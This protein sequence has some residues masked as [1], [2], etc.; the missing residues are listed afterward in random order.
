MRA[1]DIALI[2]FRL[3]A[4]WFAVSAIQALVELL[5][6]WKSFYAQISSSMVGV[7]NPLT[8]RQ[9]FL[10]TTSAMVGRTMVGIGLW[11]LAPHLARVS[12]PDLSAP[13]VLQPSRA[14]LFHAASFLAGVWLLGAAVPG[15]VF[16]GI[17]VFR[18]GLTRWM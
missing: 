13:T 18:N 17:D 16:F 9:L 11:W 15:L 4:L 1:R 8:E 2:G 3:L 7:S 5:L 12:F 6:S 14:D 10:L